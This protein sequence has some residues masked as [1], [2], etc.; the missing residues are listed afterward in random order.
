MMAGEAP[1]SLPL[2]N[3]SHSNQSIAINCITLNEGQ[4]FINSWVY[5]IN[6]GTKQAL[7]STLP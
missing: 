3:T 1:P 2:V 6:T 7:I 5:L 4:H